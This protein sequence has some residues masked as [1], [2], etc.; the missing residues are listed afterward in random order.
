MTS[1]I[2]NVDGPMYME[3]S[4]L[5]HPRCALTM[6]IDYVKQNGTLVVLASHRAWTSSFV[7]A[8]LK[9]FLAYSR[10]CTCAS[11]AR[12]PWKGSKRKFK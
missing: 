12:I 3:N 8:R 2:S 1:G 6:P 11:E 5:A 7:F 9:V 4:L 10:A